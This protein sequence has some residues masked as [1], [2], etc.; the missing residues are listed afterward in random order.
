RMTGG[1]FGGAAIAL[2]PSDRVAAAADA[3]ATAFT[4]SGFAAPHVST[5]TPS[6]G[7]RR[8]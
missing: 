7:A 2:V 1:G 5:V 6:P 4:A 3:V 8:D